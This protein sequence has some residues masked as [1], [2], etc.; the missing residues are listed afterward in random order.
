M[1]KYEVISSLL[2]HTQRPQ[3]YPE[4]LRSQIP[5]DPKCPKWILYD[6]GHKLGRAVAF[7]C[8]QKRSLHTN[9]G[10]Q[11]TH[12]HLPTTIAILLL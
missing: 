2:C 8:L 5:T 12:R 3:V 1:T 10:K 4:E 9:G 6:M 7:Y 11:D